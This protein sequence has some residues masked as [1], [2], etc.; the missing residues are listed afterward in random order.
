MTT[1]PIPATAKSGT[2]GKGWQQAPTGLVQFL[3]SL[4]MTTERLDARMLSQ[5]L[6]HH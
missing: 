4:Q 3:E 6:A 5:R 2:V 1:C